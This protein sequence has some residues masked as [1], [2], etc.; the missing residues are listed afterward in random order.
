MLLEQLHG[1][2]GREDLPALTDRDADG[3]ADCDIGAVEFVPE[4]HGSVMLIAGAT[5]L[6]LHCRRRR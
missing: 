2:A 5:F 3:F 4:S 1:I 6:G